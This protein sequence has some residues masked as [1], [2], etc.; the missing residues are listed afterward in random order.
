MLDSKEG[1]LLYK[2]DYQNMVKSKKC[3]TFNIKPTS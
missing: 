2:R 3:K 1:K